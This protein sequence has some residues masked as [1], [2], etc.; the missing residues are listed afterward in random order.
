MRDSLTTMQAA[1]LM[2]YECNKMSQD[3]IGLSYQVHGLR[4]ANSMGL[5]R[6]SPRIAAA[7]AP[8]G[9]AVQ[10]WERARAVS[11]WGSYNYQ[12]WVGPFE[13]LRVRQDFHADPRRLTSFSFQSPPLLGRQPPIPIPRYAQQNQDRKCVVLLSCAA[14]TALLM[15]PISCHF[16]SLLP[17]LRHSKRD[18]HSPLR[19]RGR[20]IRLPPQSRANRDPLPE[21]LLLP[22][23]PS[24]RAQHRPRRQQRQRK[25]STPH[26]LLLHLATPVQTLSQRRSRRP[27]SHN[28]ISRASTRDK[29][30]RRQ[31][32]VGSARPLPAE[33][34]LRHLPSRPAA[35]HGHWRL[36]CPRRADPGSGVLDGIARGGTLL[37]NLH[38][39]PAIAGR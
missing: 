16:R 2:A 8:R 1:Y 33:I 29:Q 38:P 12:V 18:L 6:V 22:Q 14:T 17:S 23:H 39:R 7:R 5:F 34:Q 25:A 4:M 32:P 30:R 37:Y 28:T 9:V 15:R 3:K 35:I 19:C 11:A 10:D 26:G 20:T 27:R 24:L 31:I 21:P 36:Q 13:R